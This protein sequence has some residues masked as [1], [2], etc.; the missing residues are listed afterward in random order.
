MKLTDLVKF[1]DVKGLGAKLE[2]LV[3]RVLGL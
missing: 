3:Y 2:W 1:S